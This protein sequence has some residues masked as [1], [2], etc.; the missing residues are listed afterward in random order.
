M[1]KNN[2]LNFNTLVSKL[3]VADINALLWE[4]ENFYI[5][6]KPFLN[7]DFNF[8]FGVELEYEEANQKDI[9]KML[10]SL[11]RYGELTNQD[12]TL[13]TNK[14]DKTVHRI[15]GK[16]IIGGEVVS[17]I[18]I[19]DRNSWREIKCI[20]SELIEYGASATESTSTHIHIDQSILE[21]RIET[22]I[23]FIKLWIIY[24][25]VIYRFLFG[26]YTNG[27]KEIAKYAK[28]VR[29]EYLRRLKKE[30]K[31]IDSLDLLIQKLKIGRHHGINFMNTST[32]KT[33]HQVKSTI[34]L[35]VPNGTLEPTII[36]NNVLFFSCLL[37]AANQISEK[38]LDSKLANIDAVS[39]EDFSNI[40]I[41]E[42]LELADILFD[43][44]ENK[45][46]F[47]RQYIKSYEISSQFKKVESFIKR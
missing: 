3:S 11:Y 22:W 34:E 47:L 17:P 18:L 37:H 21:N 41:Y 16:D 6:Y 29:T 36:Q 2:K 32:T 7:I 43:N 44:I 1:N 38:F 45:K 23:N 4:I 31:D 33:T 14:D 28:P 24:E 26:E 12:G 35:R 27:R 13:W 20:C 8:K 19:N 40:Y 10:K 46:R 30:I 15:V 9:T 5:E 39:A 25:E 42:A